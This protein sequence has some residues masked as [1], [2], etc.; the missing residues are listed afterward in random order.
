MNPSTLM[1]ASAGIVGLLGL[2]HLLFTFL[3]PKLRPRDESMVEAMENATPTLTPRTTIWKMWIGF[4]AS[5]SLGLLL[6]S[7]V[8][9]YLALAQSELLFDSLFLQMLGLALLA[10]YVLLAR[11]YWFVTP[12]LGAGLA[13][14]LYAGGLVL[15]R[16]A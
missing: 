4:N 13:L 15:A 16:A 11:L 14:L 10:A 2:A 1:A 7:A 12:L 9:G 8:Y 5:H 3:G 6:F